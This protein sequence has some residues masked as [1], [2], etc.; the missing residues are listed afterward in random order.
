L[1]DVVFLASFAAARQVHKIDA[2]FE[3]NLFE[4]DE[5][6]HRT[7]RTLSLWMVVVPGDQGEPVII[8][9]PEDF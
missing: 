3:V 5:V 2:A 1:W 9:F 6:S 4:A 8:G 7:H